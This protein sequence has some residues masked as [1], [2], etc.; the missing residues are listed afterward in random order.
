MKIK[1]NIIAAMLFTAVAFP[2]HA[3]LW[4]WSKNSRLEPKDAIAAYR[5]PTLGLDVRVYEWSP[6][7]SPDT[8]CVMAFGQTNPVGLQCFPK[9]SKLEP[10]Q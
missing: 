10:A 6:K 2:A 7:S 4:A 8:V 3:D 9:N 1:T 5:V